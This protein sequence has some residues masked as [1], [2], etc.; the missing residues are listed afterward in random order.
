MKIAAQRT[1]PIV[2]TF[3]TLQGEG[4]HTGKKAFFIRTSGCHVGC[5]F[6][7]TKYS[8]DILPGQHRDVEN[9]TDEVENAQCQFAVITGGEPTMHDLKPLTDALRQIHIP[10]HLETSGVCPLTGDWDWICLS[11]K[12]FK[13]CLEEYFQIADELKI[14]VNHPSDLTW[15]QELAHKVRRQTHRYLQPEWT[16]RGSSI[17]WIRDFCKKYSD[18]NVSFQMHKYIGIP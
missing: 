3:E 14:V 12:K 15:A 8:W 17:G 10:A 18:W 5:H 7:D 9:I 2:E 13:P 11:P 1:L 6:C 16:K 4:Y